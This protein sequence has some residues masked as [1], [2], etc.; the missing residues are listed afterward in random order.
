MEE[1]GSSKHMGYVERASLNE[2]LVP[3]RNNGVEISNMAMDDR[4]GWAAGWFAEVPSQNINEIDGN[5]R[6]TGR[7][8][9]V[10]YQ[11]G[12]VERP[13][14]WPVPARAVK[15]TLRSFDSWSTS[16]AFFFSLK[17]G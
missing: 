17:F 8:F 12:E 10:P 9:G 15:P 7:L 16:D 4:M 14:M 6:V 2:A 5:P 13:S 1:L 11:S 3:S